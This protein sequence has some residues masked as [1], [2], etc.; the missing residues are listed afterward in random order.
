MRTTHEN[1]A[2]NC[3]ANAVTSVSAMTYTCCRIIDQVS[4]SFAYSFFLYWLIWSTWWAPC[5]AIRPRT[6]SLGKLWGLIPLKN[7]SMSAAL[8]SKRASALS[9]CGVFSAMVAS[10][11]SLTA[12]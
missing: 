6:V 7:V 3:F 5:A 4:S 8:D 1:L 11:Y 10:E 2:G 9:C 12:P